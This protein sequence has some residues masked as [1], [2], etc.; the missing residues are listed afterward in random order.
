M[1]RQTRNSADV[2]AAGRASLTCNF[3]DFTAV[4]FFMGKSEKLRLIK[5]SLWY[6]NFRPFAI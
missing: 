4:V 3:S 2:G 6:E 5:V 1:Q